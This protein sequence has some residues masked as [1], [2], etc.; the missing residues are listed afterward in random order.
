M[1]G[2]TRQNYDEYF[3]QRELKRAQEAELKAAQ[4]KDA[5]GPKV[6]VLPGGKVPE[7]DF[8]PSEVAPSSLSSAGSKM[9]ANMA[10]DAASKGSLA[11]TAGGAMM[12]TGNPYLMAGGLGLSV[13]AAG[14]QNKRAAEEKQRQEYNER[15]KERQ[16]MMAQIAS[17]GIR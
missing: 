13:L 10:Q 9:G 4:I 15:I 17:M 12:M 8:D 2:Y 16:L 11:G 1:S 7:S 3:K 14:E 5:A 6:E